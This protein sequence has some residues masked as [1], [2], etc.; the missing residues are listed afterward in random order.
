MLGRASGRRSGR[1]LAS[2]GGGLGK[3][4]NF[5]IWGRDGAQ[6][7]RNPLQT[8][9]QAFGNPQRPSRPSEAVSLRRPLEAP[10]GRP[11][12]SFKSLEKSGSQPKTRKG[13][14]LGGC[15]RK[16]GVGRT[17]QH[18]NS[19]FVGHE[20]CAVARYAASPH[21]WVC[22]GAISTCYLQP[23]RSKTP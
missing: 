14:K 2:P 9:H 6:K 11:I 21:P 20:R 8:R 22:R 15:L 19:W 17:N 5:R 16:Q 12:V 3:M 7:T 23:P 4:L 18:T 10:C 1:P 13:I